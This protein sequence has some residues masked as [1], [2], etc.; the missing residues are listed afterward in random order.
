MSF[1]HAFDTFS[2]SFINRKLKN[3]LKMIKKSTYLVKILERAV[4]FSRFF[5][6]A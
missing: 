3:L 4:L 1:E 2:V 5:N 6:D